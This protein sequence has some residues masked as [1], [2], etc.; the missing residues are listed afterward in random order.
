MY[1]MIFTKTL[2]TFQMASPHFGSFI[3]ISLLKPKLFEYGIENSP[4]KSCPHTKMQ[5]FKSRYNIKF[6]L[7][8]KNRESNEPV[9]H[10]FCL[11]LKKEKA[12][13]WCSST[14]Y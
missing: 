6:C 13:S 11:E 2:S 10:V 14:N 5:Q 9:R 12:M 1:V 3:I 8:Y 7:E 4:R